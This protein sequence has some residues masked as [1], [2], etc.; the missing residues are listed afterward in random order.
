MNLS[1]KNRFIEEGFNYIYKRA[2]EMVQWL[3]ALDTL[4]KDGFNPATTWQLN[5]SCRGLD[6]LTQTYM[7]AKHQCAQNKPFKLGNGSMCL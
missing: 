5:S 6:I 3:R 7:Q 1:Q 4:P 2:G